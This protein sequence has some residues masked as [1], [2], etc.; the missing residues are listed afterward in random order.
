MIVIPKTYETNVSLADGVVFIEQEIENGG[1]IC[2]T[3]P[4][5]YV[6]DVCNALQAAKECAKGG[7]R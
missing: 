6:D 3:I 2:L 1:S 7:G 5:H 4:L